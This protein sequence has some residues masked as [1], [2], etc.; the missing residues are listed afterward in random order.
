[1]GI[2]LDEM[3]ISLI[4]IR[5]TGFKNVSVLFSDKRIKK[6]C[7]I[8]TDFDESFINTEI[9][10]VDNDAVRARK[11]KS[12]ESQKRGS[13]RKDSLGDL[14]KHNR[15]VQSFYAPHTFEVDLIAVGNKELL[16]SMLPSIYSSEATIEKAAKD[17]R[18]ENISVYGSRTLAIA[19][20]MGKGWL[21]ILLGKGIDP[22]VIIPSYIIKALRFSQPK[23]KISVWQDIIKYRLLRYWK[24]SPELKMECVKIYKM[25]DLIA[26]DEKS[27]DDLINEMSEKLPDDR[28]NDILSEY[29]DV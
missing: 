11:N 7:S 17:L 29:K 18:S 15:W 8:I 6:R 20:K 25:F 26:K 22:D 19:E 14:Y 2:S 27:F 24:K 21:A 23:I 4:N 13:E 28:I 12:L 16:I 1:M 3:G 9:T 5:S 10:D